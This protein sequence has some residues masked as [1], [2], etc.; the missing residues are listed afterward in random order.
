MVHGL[1]G[2]GDQDE[3][4]QVHESGTLGALI[5]TIAFWVC[6]LHPIKVPFNWLSAKRNAWFG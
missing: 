1:D 3:V 5:D 6:G 4:E 2:P